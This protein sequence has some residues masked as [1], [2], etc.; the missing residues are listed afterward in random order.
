MNTPIPSKI[1]LLPKAG[2]LELSYGDAETHRLS[3]EFLRVHSP[4]AEVKG[5]GPGTEI[6]QHGKKG[7]GI[8]QIEPVGNYAIRI[9]FSDK[10]NSGLFDWGLLY[11]FCLQQDQMWQSYL[12]KLE[13]AGKSRE[14]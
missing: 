6:L 12:E 8:T 9:H 3:F 13:A 5:H 11:K 14:K 1:R 7:V 4:S 10:H 2:V